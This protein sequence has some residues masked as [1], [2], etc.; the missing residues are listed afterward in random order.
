MGSSS[1]T[2]SPAELSR[3]QRRTV[4]TLIGAQIFASIAISAGIAMG[5]LILEQATGSASIAG[6]SQAASTLGAALVAVPAASLAL[7]RG[8]RI[9]L[10]VTY[11][12]AAVGA[13]V[14]VAGSVLSAPALVIAGMLAFGAGQAGSLQTRFAGVDLAAASARGRTLS[15]LLFAVTIGGVLGP[16]L[17]GPAGRW[18]ERIGL[19]PYAGP[20]LVSAVLLLVAAAWVQVLLRPDPLLVASEVAAE[21]GDARPGP[22]GRAVVSAKLPL[23]RSLEMIWR[24]A[25]GRAGL[26]AVAGGHAA[27]VGVMVMTP[28]HIANEGHGIE[29]VGIIISGH[30]LGMYAFSPVMGWIADRYGAPVTVLLGA[31]ILLAA[32]TVS[33]LAGGSAM[34][35]LGVGLLLLGLG[36][37]AC[38]VGG[39][40]LVTSVTDAAHAPSVQ[41]ASDLVMGLSAAA[42]AMLSGVVVELVSYAALAAVAAILVV[43]MVL[44]VIADRRSAA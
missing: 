19:E 23:R 7:A 6:F 35:L 8:R 12:T 13:A 4:G 14:V 29:V 15:L 36:W 30:V 25:R 38:L 40:L 11:L 5:G 32:C 34:V 37:S 17:A 16:N 28:V 41:G 42:V 22:R 9:S 21:S 43:P 10:G 26:L 20:I 24:T 33:I 1:G 27:M 31:G 18:A 39:S 44:A 2:R 3:L